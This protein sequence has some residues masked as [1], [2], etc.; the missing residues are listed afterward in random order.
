MNIT[1]LKH[2]IDLAI[3]KPLDHK[4]LDKDVEYFLANGIVCY[5]NTSCSIHYMITDAIREITNV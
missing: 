2:Y 1:D 4:N 3:M 5:L